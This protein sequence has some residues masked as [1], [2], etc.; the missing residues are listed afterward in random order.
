MTHE[1]TGKNVYDEEL[2]YENGSENQDI[3]WTTD[4]FRIEWG[5]TDT[6]I[7]GAYMLEDTLMVAMTVKGEAGIYCFDGTDFHLVQELGGLSLEDNYGTLLNQIEYP[8]HLLIPFRDKD[9]QGIM[10]VIGR[11][12]H[13]YYLHIP[14][15]TLPVS[16]TDP[17]VKM[18]NSLADRQ[19]LTMT[20]VD[21][22]ELLYSGVRGDENQYYTLLPDS[23]YLWRTYTVNE[24]T[25][26]VEDLRIEHNS[27]D[28]GFYR[29]NNSDWQDTIL[30]AFK[31]EL[32]PAAP[33]N[34]NFEDYD[35]PRFHLRASAYGNMVIF[36]FPNTSPQ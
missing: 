24:S 7:S 35:S 2:Y 13:L 23:S 36:I 19:P 26:F 6:V 34:S 28:E 30:S 32:T 10:H 3:L 18:V 17:T 5:D 16:I 29:L 25:G 8:N 9:I 4:A 15:R 11:T 21:N 27:F 31:S 14:T 12:I 20:E 33:Y 22:I 1:K